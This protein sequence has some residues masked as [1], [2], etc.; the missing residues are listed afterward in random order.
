MEI[1]FRRYVLGISVATALLAGCGLPQ[2]MSKGQDDTQAPSPAT[3]QTPLHP[4]DV[5]AKNSDLLYVANQ[6]S[7]TVYTY[8]GGN[9]VGTLSSGETGGLC[10]DKAGDVFV[11]EANWIFEY[12]HGGSQPVRILHDPAN[13]I[14]CSVDA[15]SGDLAVAGYYGVA[16]YKHARGRARIY[17]GKRIAFFFCAFDDKGDL[18]VDGQNEG[19][20]Y[21]LAELPSGAGEFTQITLSQGIAWPGGL[22]WYRGL[23]AA[24]SGTASGINLFEITRNYAYLIKTVPTDSADDI[25][26]FHIEGP[27]MIVPSISCYARCSNVFL[28]HFPAGGI[29]TKMI[30]QSV[31]LPVA[32]AVSVK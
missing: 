19:Y 14:G 9:Y 3:S 5:S 6:N 27:R 24:S 25:G 31:Y 12:T 23:L 13:P 22:Q 16:I 30:T 4:L 18:F 8:P 15:R 28:Y 17:I 26:Q 29:P 11:T 21:V 20:A 10:A 2:S 1:L 7:V 32:V